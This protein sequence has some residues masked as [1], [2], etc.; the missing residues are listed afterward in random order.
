MGQGVAHATGCRDD[1]VAIPRPVR[2]PRNRSEL[3]V[4][5]YYDP[6][7]GRYI[8]QDPLGLTPAPNPAGYVDNP[9]SAAD[10]LGLNGTKRKH[11]DGGN[12]QPTSNADKKP[13]L[14]NER[15]KFQ[16]DTHNKSQADK[17]STPQGTGY[18]NG[19]GNHQRHIISYQTM[20]KNLENWVGANHKPGTPEYDAAIKKYTDK[21][22]GMNSNYENLPL[23]AVP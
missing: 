10:P 4:N 3:H 5:R 8:S 16:R 1:T 15:P 18:N 19:A 6:A 22:S 9:H 12:Q 2:R 7:I 14:G 21:L 20:K 23:K 11:P 13:K 17:T